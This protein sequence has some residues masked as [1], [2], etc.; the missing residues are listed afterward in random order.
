MGGRLLLSSHMDADAWRRVMSTFAAAPRRRLAAAHTLLAVRWRRARGGRRGDGVVAASTRDMLA[1]PTAG[2]TMMRRVGDAMLS[3]D[4]AGVVAAHCR[5][6]LSEQLDAAPPA[7]G[8][9]RMLVAGHDAAAGAPP[10]WALQ[11]TEIYA[12]HRSRDPNPPAL[13]ALPPYQLLV[14]A[15]GRRPTSKLPR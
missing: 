1:N 5:Y 6:L 4:G 7:E 10:T 8:L 15:C 13:S 12:A 2:D 11:A 3:R 9:P 14:P